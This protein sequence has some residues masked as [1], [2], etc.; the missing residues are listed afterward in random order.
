[1]RKCL[2]VM[3][4][5]IGTASPGWAA[6]IAGKWGIGAGVLG[7]GGEISLIRGHSERTAWLFEVQLSGSNGNEQVE[8]T[9][10]GGPALTPVDRNS[11]SFSIAAGPGLRRYSRSPSEFSPYFDVSIRG[12]YRRSHTTGSP[13]YTGIGTG[14]GLGFGLEY[15]TRWHF[16]VAAHAPVANLSWFRDRADHGD[17]LYVEKRGEIRATIAVRPSL[18]VR[19]YF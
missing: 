6:D 16:S 4:L 11:S 14:L 2:L 15:F 12:T 8:Y 3:T 10:P 18:F 17:G 13:T 1:M 19:G 5:S 9:T 7:G